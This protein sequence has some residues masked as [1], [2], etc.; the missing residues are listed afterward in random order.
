MDVF[1][2][3]QALH[4]LGADV[5]AY[6]NLYLHFFSMKMSLEAFARFFFP[7]L[8]PAI[9]AAFLLDEPVRTQSAFSGDKHVPD[10]FIIFRGIHEVLEFISG[11][12]DIVEYLEILP[13]VRF[14]SV[15][16]NQKTIHQS[17]LG[18][19]VGKVADVLEGLPGLHQDV[20]DRYRKL[21]I[22]PGLYVVFLQWSE[23]G[24]EV[25]QID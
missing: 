3:L 4:F 7:E 24:K 20:N 10:L 1:G 8:L 9:A 6:P 14:R 25:I 18:D 23:N 12:P 13:Y 2:Q 11:L 15:L 22:S 21:R 19:V 17:F 5:F 16:A